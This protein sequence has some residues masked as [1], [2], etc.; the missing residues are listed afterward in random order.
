MMF[1]GDQ[2]SAKQRPDSY[3][4]PSSLCAA[5]E[6]LDRIR[7]NDDAVRL[8]LRKFA[9]TMNDSLVGVRIVII[10]PAVA[11]MTV[12]PHN[13]AFVDVVT[14]DLR[15]WLGHKARKIDAVFSLGILFVSILVPGKNKKLNITNIIV[16][17]PSLLQLRFVTPKTCLKVSALLSFTTTM[18]ARPVCFRPAQ[19]PSNSTPAIR[20]VSCPRVLRP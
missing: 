14:N 16:R 12:G 1:N 9:T 4:P 5:E 15:S 17:S 19:G 20:M 10:H 7:R 2:F 6:S 18:K 8:E 3:Q 11:C 13:R